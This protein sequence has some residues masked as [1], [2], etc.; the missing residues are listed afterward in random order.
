MPRRLGGDRTE[1]SR[2]PQTFGAVAGR[3]LIG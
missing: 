2:E 3:G 1:W